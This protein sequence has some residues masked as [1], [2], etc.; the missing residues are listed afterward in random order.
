MFKHG[1]E[2]ASLAS[3]AVCRE[4]VTVFASCTK[5]KGLAST[6]THA[7]GGTT[8]GLG[9]TQRKGKPFV[10]FF[11]FLSLSLFILQREW[12]SS[13]LRA[14]YRYKDISPYAAGLLLVPR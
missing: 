11:Q 9:T 10:E 13:N 8:A 4:S 2:V 7:R 5:K 3:G 6:S 12:A 14:Q 1:W